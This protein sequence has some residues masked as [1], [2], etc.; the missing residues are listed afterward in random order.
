[1]HEQVRIAP[2]RRGEMRVR[3]ERRGRNGRDRRA[4][5]RPGSASAAAPIRSGSR[6]DACAPSSAAPRNRAGVTWSMRRQRQL[7]FACRN[8]SRSSYFDAGG[9]A[10]T[11]YGAGMLR[12]CRNFAASTLAAIMHSSISLC[13]S[14]R[15][16]A[17]SCTTSPVGAEAELDL[18]CFRNRSRRASGAPWPAPCR[19]DAGAS[20]CGITSASSCARVGVL[21]ADRLPHARVGQARVRAHHRRI[22]LRARDFAVAVD[23]HV[24]HHAQALDLRIQRADAVRQRLRQH[25]HDEA[26]EI[27]RRARGCTPPRRAALPGCT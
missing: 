18:A 4:G 7:E 10:C 13:A 21:L 17:P 20:S 2:D 3:V 15:S 5:T 1:M 11:R 23:L 25:R 24:A 19:A 22:E 12:L 14:L 9:G 6:R 27:H 8:S 26:G 16:C